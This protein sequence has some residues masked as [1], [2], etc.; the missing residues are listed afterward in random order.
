MEN[1]AQTFWTRIP[2]PPLPPPKKNKIGEFFSQ[3]SGNMQLKY[4]YFSH[5]CKINHPKNGVG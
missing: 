3:N 1:S 4:F 2:I 5:F